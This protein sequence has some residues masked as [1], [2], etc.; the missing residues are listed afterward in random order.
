MNITP[1]NNINSINNYQLYKNKINF[2]GQTQT[3]PQTHGS[4]TVTITKNRNRGAYTFAN[5]NLLGRCNA[6]CYFCV[7]KDMSGELEGKNQLNTH[8]SKW[9]N[10]DKFLDSCEQKGVKKLYLT[11]QTAD[12]LQYKHIDELIDYLQN[13]GFTVGVRSN[14]FLA[15]KKMAALH[16][17]QDEIGYSIHSLKPE[18]N[19]KI[20][21]RSHV[22]NWDV[23]IP[24]SGDNV[25]V[26]IVLNR[27]N[28]D[29]FDDLI[30]YLSQFRN[31]RYIQVRKISTDN[32]SE[33]LGE[34]IKLYEDFYQEF[35]KTH[36]QKGSFF[37]APQYELYGKEVD[38]WRAVE[39][40]TVSSLNYF[41]D[42]TISDEYFVV[43]GYLKNMK[44]NPL[45]KILQF[46]KRVLRRK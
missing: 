43:E 40:T 22:P 20:M 45:T 42:G 17:M 14:G 6:D 35:A 41:T 3:V 11:G 13:R 12:G 16:K 37:A 24:N 4:D 44:K 25:R 1:L 33:L 32:R 28:V 29:E 34:D 21:G 7:S 46:A 19:R 36:E 15:E 5:I 39:E 23:I 26:A 8:F 18:V 27:H 31:V 38:F 10:F 2:K 9:K 30:K